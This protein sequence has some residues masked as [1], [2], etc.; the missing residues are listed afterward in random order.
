MILPL[1][2]PLFSFC[3]LPQSLFTVFTKYLLI[4]DHIILSCIKVFSRVL[5]FVGVFLFV[6]M[7]TF[8]FFH[9]FAWLTYISSLSLTQNTHTYT[10]T[11]MMKVPLFWAPV[12]LLLALA[13]NYNA[14]LY[15]FHPMGK[16]S[17]NLEIAFY[18]P[19]PIEWLQECLLHSR[20]SKGTQQKNR[21]HVH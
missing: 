9:Q 20:Y 15:M 11:Y 5:G 19:F 10:Y 14:V 1:S 4:S 17:Q 12:Q 7:D 3:S 2:L 16:S 18:S 8:L 13:Q 21:E 6:L